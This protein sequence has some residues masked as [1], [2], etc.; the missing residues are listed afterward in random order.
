MATE[1]LS[2]VTHGGYDKHHFGSGL[3]LENLRSNPGGAEDTSAKR[4]IEHGFT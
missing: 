4:R 1:H 3:Q 2:F